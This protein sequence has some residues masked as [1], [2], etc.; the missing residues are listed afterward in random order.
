MN[1]TE[2]FLWHREKDSNPHRRSQSPACYLYTIPVYTSKEYYN[3]FMWI[4]KVFL[5]YCSAP[6]LSGIAQRFNSRQTSAARR[7]SDCETG[8]A[9]QY[10]AGR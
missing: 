2:C 7:T 8:F 5:S 6:D 9:L 3:R 10:R 4:V 1:R